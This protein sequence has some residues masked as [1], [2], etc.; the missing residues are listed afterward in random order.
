MPTEFLRSVA[1]YLVSS[2]S[3]EALPEL[4]ETI[5]EIQEFYAASP[6]AKQT[7]THIRRVQAHVHERS[8]RPG[9]PIPEDET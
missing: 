7:S 1:Y 8:E 6:Q 9:F 4:I 3:S 2:I 5:K